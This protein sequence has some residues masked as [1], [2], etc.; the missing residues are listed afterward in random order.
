MIHA[1]GG[2]QH[3][4]TSE[5]LTDAAEACCCRCFSTNA[6][7]GN[8]MDIRIKGKGRVG[9]EKPGIIQEETMEKTGFS[10]IFFYDVPELRRSAE[11]VQQP[12]SI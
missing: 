11:I 2:R 6:A 5:M 12:D 3:G 4:K 7:G 1:G 8:S 10:R 9:I